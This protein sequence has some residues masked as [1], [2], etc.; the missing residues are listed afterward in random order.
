MGVNFF[1]SGHGNRRPGEKRRRLLKL[2]GP[3]KELQE[4]LGGGVAASSVP[5]KVLPDGKRTLQGGKVGNHRPDKQASIPGGVIAKDYG[6]DKKQWCGGGEAP[7]CD[8]SEE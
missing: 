8:S 4:A 3:I 5:G 1:L 6:H 2:R 7:E